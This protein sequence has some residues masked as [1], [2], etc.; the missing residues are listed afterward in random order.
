MAALTGNTIAS[1]YKDLLQVSNSNSGVDGTLRS[2]EDGEGTASVLQISSSAVKVGGTVDLDGAVT[3][4]E[5][6]AD[7]DF[8]VESNGNTHMLFVDA[9]DNR[10]GIGTDDPLVTTHIH[11]DDETSLYITTDSDS[12]DTGIWMGHDIDGTAAYTGIVYDRSDFKLK[13]FNANSIADHLVISNDGH[14]GISTS[15]FES[16]HSNW[17][18]ILQIS[19]TTTLGNYNNTDTYLLENAYHD[20]A[21]KYQT[22]SHASKLTN[23]GGSYVFSV[24]D[25]GSADATITWRDAFTIN[26]NGDSIFSG[27]Y[28]VGIGE[29]TPG[30]Q[31]EIREDNTS[32]DATTFHEIVRINNQ[33]GNAEHRSAMIG[34]STYTSGTPT[35]YMGART[36]DS[37][38]QTAFEVGVH[39]GATLEERFRVASESNTR[40]DITST[41][42]GANQPSQK[43]R[44]R[45]HHANAGDGLRT[46]AEI[47]SIKHN[48]TGGGVGG[49]LLFYTNNT[50]NTMTERMHIDQLGNIT[51]PTQ[52]AFLAIPASTQQN[53]GNNTKIEFDTEIFDQGGNF[54]N[55]TFTAPVD[56]RY[57]L[58]GWLRCTGGLDTATEYQ[59]FQLVTSNRSYTWIID[60]DMFDSSGA[61]FT[62][63]FAVLA[64]MDVNDTAVINHFYY[65]GTVSL[66]I[67]TDSFFSGYLVA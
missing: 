21:W 52:P 42:T 37:G 14:I 6:S 26:N 60:P 17:D 2:V 65:A 36:E 38:A 1:T 47:K 53:P 62:I 55:D 27:D 18:G 8:R 57:Q 51:Q 11:S 20:G 35:M 16:W 5:S 46:F 44:F 64:D 3:I 28:K 56:G 63:N 29:G 4:N 12:R 43:I 61:H 19:A 13:L 9:G 24:A 32:V 10:V 67:D 22:A 59:G 7:V 41:P 33:T 50:S 15:S 66:D 25:S 48:N 49:D 58:Q 34:F 39:S 45:G 30:A 23:Q 40:I 54:S 31:L